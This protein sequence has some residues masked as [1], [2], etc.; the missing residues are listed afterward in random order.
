MKVSSIQLILLTLWLKMLSKFSTNL[1][2]YSSVRLLG[3]TSS[4]IPPLQNKMAKQRPMN[5][6]LELHKKQ[7][8]SPWF[9]ILPAK[10]KETP[11]RGLSKKNCS[12]GRHTHTA[13]M[14]SQ[15]EWANIVSALVMLFPR[16][17]G[18]VNKKITQRKMWTNNLTPLQTLAVFVS[19]LFNSI[20]IK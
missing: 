19:G 11:P 18:R 10:H 9:S 6:Y 1:L 2:H 5:I 4:N 20:W 7:C 16:L 15:N 17:R 13:M 3:H 12:F 14:S 8:Q